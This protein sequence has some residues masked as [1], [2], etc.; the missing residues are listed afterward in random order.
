MYENKCY[1]KNDYQNHPHYLVNSFFFN[2]SK[3]KPT[4][5]FHHYISHFRTNLKV[6]WGSE[7]AKNT[8]IKIWDFW[9]W[10]T[11]I[12]N[13]SA[14]FHR[15]Q[16]KVHARQITLLW[17]APTLTPRNTYILYQKSRVKVGISKPKYF[18]GSNEFSKNAT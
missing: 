1:L 13:G 18:L 15:C 2:P 16:A 7:I 17:K 12:T 6:Y 10:I 9:L 14:R 4:W 5:P 11:T 8:E 3:A